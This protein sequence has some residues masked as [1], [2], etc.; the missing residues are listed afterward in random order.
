MLALAAIG[1]WPDQ[2][3]INVLTIAETWGMIARF[4]TR[5]HLIW[6]PGALRFFLAGLIVLRPETPSERR[7]E[8]SIRMSPM[9]TD[10]MHH[11]QDVHTYHPGDDGRLMVVGAHHAPH[12]R[13]VRG[14]GSPP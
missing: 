7:H 13:A 10:L 6:S 1:E 11:L 9:F 12:H 8:R 5:F 2:E 14:E 3:A 4:L